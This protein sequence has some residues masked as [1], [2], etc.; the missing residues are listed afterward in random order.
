MTL[1]GLLRAGTG[2]IGIELDILRGVLRAERDNRLF[3]MRGAGTVA[4]DVVNAT[5]VHGNQ[6]LPSMMWNR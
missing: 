3:T 4:V 5:S 6:P 1:E 2:L